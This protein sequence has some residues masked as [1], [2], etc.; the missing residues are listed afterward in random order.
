MKRLL[1]HSEDNGLDPKLLGK[2]YTS[3]SLSPLLTPLLP[4]PATIFGDILLRAPA[5][6]RRT[7]SKKQLGPIS[8]KKATFVYQFLVNDL[9]V[10]YR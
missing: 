2:N 8:R 5:N 1:S 7:L 10:D 3:P 6:E 9:T 4:P